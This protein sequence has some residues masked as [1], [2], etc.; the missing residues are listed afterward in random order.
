MLYKL[1]PLNVYFFTNN[2]LKQFIGILFVMPIVKSSRD[3]WAEKNK[4]CKDH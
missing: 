1:I 4:I 3:Y 2:E